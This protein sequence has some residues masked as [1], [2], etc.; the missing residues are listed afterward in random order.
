MYK[1]LIMSVIAIL[2]LPQS[3]FQAFLRLVASQLNPAI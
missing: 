3:Q 1:S 2:Q